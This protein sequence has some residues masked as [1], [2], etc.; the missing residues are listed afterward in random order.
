MSLISYTNKQDGVDAVNAASLNTPFNAIYDEF[1][2]NIDNN[3]LA[4]NAVTTDKL[5]DDA[6][7]AAKVNFGGAGTGIWWEEIGRTTLS[8]AGDSISATVTAK[9]YLKFIAFV[10]TTGGTGDVQLRFNGDSGANYSWSVT[11]IDGNAYATGVN[12]TGITLD[13][14]T[15]ASGNIGRYEITVIPNLAAKSKLVSSEGWYTAPGAGN[16][17]VP[18]KT[19]GQWANVLAQITTVALVNTG[20]GDF[21]I[22]SEL[23]ILGHD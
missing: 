6:V 19:W 18:L 10:E 5:I 7:T 22:G 12:Q 14:T 9:K 3:N 20:T 13:A 11:A 16:F 1:N 2:G 17:P 15:L 21:A 4:N 8:V 23:I